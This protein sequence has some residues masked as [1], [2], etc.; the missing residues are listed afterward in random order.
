MNPIVKSVEAGD[1]PQFLGKRCISACI[2]IT[3]DQSVCEDCN[4]SAQ[5]RPVLAVLVDCLYFR[6]DRTLSKS[7]NTHQI[8]YIHYARMYSEYILA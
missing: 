8:L 5:T 2:T 1:M 3:Y 7:W 6:E 4:D